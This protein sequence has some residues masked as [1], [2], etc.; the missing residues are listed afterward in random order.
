MAAGGCELAAVS[1]SDGKQPVLLVRERTE[2]RGVLQLRLVGWFLVGT[3]GLEYNFST[4][5]GR[6]FFCFVF[7]LDQLVG[8]LSVG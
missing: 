3:G 7:N 5:S 2:L 8:K 4:V 1:Y 6:L